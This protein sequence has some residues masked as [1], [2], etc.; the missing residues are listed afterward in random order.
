MER[1]LIEKMG[2]AMGLRPQ[3]SPYTDAEKHM[4]QAFFGHVF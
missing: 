2:H 3:T 1:E 4:G